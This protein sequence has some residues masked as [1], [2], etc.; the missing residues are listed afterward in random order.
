MDMDIFAVLADPT[1]RAMLELLANQDRT[2]GE[3]VK[4]FPRLTQPAVSKHLKSLLKIGLVEARPQARQRV[5]ALIPHRL[6]EI[7][8]WLNRFR[9][10]SNNLR[11]TIE[12]QIPNSPQPVGRIVRRRID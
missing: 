3:L 9:G 2:A 8:K 4:A 6:D 7:A 11:V 5:Y 10:R 1:R 12:S